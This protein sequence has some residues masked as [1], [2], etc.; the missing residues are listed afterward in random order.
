MPNFSIRTKLLLLFL[1]IS[2][3]VSSVLTAVGWLNGKKSVQKEVFDQLVSV[4]NGKASQ[5]E[6]YFSSIQKS[7]A[8]GN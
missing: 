8:H 1:L 6:N 4:R 2:I 7:V 3:L 5:I